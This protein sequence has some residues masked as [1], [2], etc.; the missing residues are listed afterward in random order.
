MDN[1]SRIIRLKL[2]GKLMVVMAA[3]LIFCQ[4]LLSATHL[5]QTDKQLHQQHQ[6]RLEASLKTLAQSIAIDVW[7]FNPGSLEVLVGPHLTDPGIRK[8]ALNDTNGNSLEL[9]NQALRNS[10]EDAVLEKAVELTLGGQQTNVGMVKLYSS[11]D[12][13]ASQLKQTMLR[14]TG[15]LVLLILI[16]AGG[17]SLALSKLVLQPLRK[18]NAALTAA[19]NSQDGVVHNP[20]FGLEDEFEEVAVS[21][22]GLS[23][24]LSG[25]IKTISQ[26]KADLQAEKE[27]TDQALNHLKQ[28]QEAL[29]QSEKQ[30]SLGSLVAGVAHEVNT[31]LGVVI[32]SI[33]CINDMVQQLLHD[34]QAGTLTKPALVS[35]LDKLNEATHLIISNTNRASQLINNFKLLSQEQHGEAQRWFNLSSYIQDVVA[36]MQDELA[37]HNIK[38]QLQIEPDIVLSSMP[39]L[40]AQLVSS[41]LSNVM[42]HAFPSGQGGNCLLRLALHPHEVCLSC[43]DQGVGIATELQKRVF[44]PFYTSKLGVGSSGLG[45]AIAYR[46]VKFNLKGDIQVHS[47]EQQGTTF[48]IR[49][50]YHAAQLD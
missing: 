36:S 24:R 45:M 43:S 34:T 12:Y 37:A 38:L 47:V 10:S 46:I 32:T 21:I 17:L 40:Y 27:R 44:D 14:Q 8:I 4:L 11:T 16:L 30:A 50:P 5:Y 6:A 31:P 42:E 7:N 25:D 22:A 39:G 48:D 41:L 3:I 20:L 23:G 49:I 1:R 2:T 26:A 15:E 35:Q 18:L 29:L 28:T 13:I 33:T 9:P 19:V